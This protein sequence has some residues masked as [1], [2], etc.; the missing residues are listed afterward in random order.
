M[1]TS[2][3]TGHKEKSEY[4][5]VNLISNPITTLS[6]LFAILSEQLLRYI[7]FLI[8]H[9]LLILLLIA[10]L[11]LSIFEGRHSEVIYYRR[12]KYEIIICLS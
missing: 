2:P 11:G 3:K 10:Y 12:F 6:T 5:P 7:K 4:K 9:Q 1:K 8:G